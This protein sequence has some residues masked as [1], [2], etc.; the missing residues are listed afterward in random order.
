MRKVDLTAVP[1]ADI[2]E[3]SKLVVPMPE[4]VEVPASLIKSLGQPEQMWVYRKDDGSAYGAVA[5]WN[6]EG[7]KKEVR[8]IV[9]DGKKF[10]TS[11]FGPNR[12]LFNSDL[13]AAR[14]LA[15]VLVVEGEKA[16]DGAAQY[17]PDGWVVT[18]WQGGSNAW[19]NTDWS[20]LAGHTVVIWPDNDGAGVNAAAEI[21][22]LL[23][24]LLV[25]TSMVQIS[26]AFADGWDLGDE[27]PDKYTGK[28]ITALL[29][30]EL[31][32]A[33]LVDVADDSVD[34]PEASS[35][36][37]DDPDQDPARRYRPLGYDKGMYYIMTDEEYQIMPY[38]SSTLMSERGL[39]TIHGDREFWEA[40]QHSAGK[41]I[42]WIAAGVNVMN[43]CR[44]MKIYDTSR[45]RGRGVWIDKDK[46]GDDRA[47]LHT[48]S[49]LFVSRPE[50]D[51]KPT[52]FVRVKS[53]WIYEMRKDIIHD[54][55]FNICASD[56][57]GRL[58]RELCQQM[59]WSSELYGDL[60]AG[61]IATAIVCGG[62]D[63]RTHLWVTGNHG[64]GKSTVVE[65][66]M[67]T[68]IGKVA[69]YP[70][71][72]TTEAGLRA[73]LQSDAIPVVFDESEGEKYAEDRLLQILALMRQASSE[74]QGAIFKGSAN[75]VAHEFNI[76]SAF[77]L[78]SIGVSL[79]QG[80][81]LSRTA[82][83]SIRPNNSYAYSERAKLEEKWNRLHDIVAMLP[84]DLPQ[85]LIAR[86]TKNLFNLRH[87]IVIFK[88]TITNILG[89]PRLGDQLGT[90]LA[91]SH[92]LYSTQ[93]L[94]M[95]QCEKYL[96][97]HNL[98]DFT[99]TKEEQEDVVLLRHLCS[100][101]IRVETNHGVQDR[102]V[103]ELIRIS[104]NV[105]EY[106]DVSYKTAISTLSRYGMR[107]DMEHGKRTG[108]WLANK[109]PPLDRL[110]QTAEFSQG[111]VNIIKRHPLAK[112]SESGLRFA[113]ATSRATFIPRQ[114]WPVE[115]A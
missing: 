60:L 70:K 42:D 59:R 35:A 44:S 66:I 101:I 56:E 84:L 54:A 32:S 31:K 92:S 17:V 69:L 20:L 102:S 61:W 2:T 41:R 28:Q 73:K 110:M 1:P 51:L 57:E 48:G 86:Q 79:K 38:N 112:Q 80:A 78:V 108:I 4:P 15:P 23:S 87:N 98:N 85:K 36:D 25:P 76:R 7:R 81:D 9:W 16:V 65:K 100:S 95:K 114:E 91:G 111:W 5:R 39:M 33:E 88:D 47:M 94:N 30:K 90:L 49:D 89:S 103:G 99:E 46:N 75:H 50:Q 13:L 68:C 24:A 11:G 64:T 107:V 105:I 104:L 52:S 10:V 67:K 113:G 62:M 45:T 96:S 109:W 3:A 27:L 106:E 58:I 97:K 34:G 55:N 43:E 63:W 19:Q 18:T 37:N 77:M 82:V 22:A 8:P 14:P 115:G 21:Q 29:K 40:Q 72:S 83:L 74:G 26:S 53:P 6:P 93:R 71:G 12:P